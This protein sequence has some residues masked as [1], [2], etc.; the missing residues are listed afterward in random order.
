MK[1]Y[2][3]QYDKMTQASVPGL[4]CILGAPTTLSMLVTNLY[5]M[6]DTYFVGKLGTSASGATGI[7]FGLMAIIQANGF[8]FGHGSGSIISRKLGAKD[9]QS[10]SEYAT[11]GCAMSLA[12]GLLIA[13][14]GLL[15]T[16]PLMYLLGSTDTILPYARVYC[17]CI[18]I[19]APA[20][21][22]SCVLNNILRYEGK[23]FFAMMGLVSGGLINIVLDALFI[24]GMGMGIEGAGVATALSQYISLAILSYMFI[25]HKCESVI[26]TRFFKRDVRKAVTIVQTGFPSL[27]RQ[28][29]G[30]ISVMVLNNFCGPFGD[31][32]I[33]AM[34]I[35][36]RVT[37]FMFSVGLGIGQ[38]Y[39]PVAGFNYGAGR[40]SRVRKG[41]FFTWAFSTGLMTIGSIIA[42]INAPQ[43]VAVFRDDASVIAIGSVA[44]RWQCA[45]LLF[46]PFTVCSNMMFQ[47]TGK[48]REA[49]I[50]A[51]FRSGLMFI[52][53]IAILANTIGLFGIEISQ[54]IA[55]VAASIA[56]IYFVVKFF[57][58]LPEDQQTE[59]VSG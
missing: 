41:F 56:C 19:A 20:M 34:S 46:V 58:E 14:V 57:R 4:I 59:T 12:M 30:S 55:D 10:A 7:V 22:V 49:S 50:L 35:A 51:T 31:A 6:A 16:N 5:N 1:K 32:A 52:P 29:L 27:I 8:M 36:S 9:K 17:R 33:A 26:S 53:V 37:N 18:L 2:D 48:S 43:I 23:A 24:M 45:G 39:Q 40:F 21:T 38:G 44:L 42:F 3:N 11:M 54:P 15:F 47:S 28:G 13:L 25:S